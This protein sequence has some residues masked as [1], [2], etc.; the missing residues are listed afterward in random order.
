[1]SKKKITRKGE[2][3]YPKSNRSGNATLV[4]S[5]AYGDN[6]AENFSKQIQQEWAHDHSESTD[7]TSTNAS[8]NENSS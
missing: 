7:E 2:K 1:M 5:Q 8:V 3:P 6:W 4:I